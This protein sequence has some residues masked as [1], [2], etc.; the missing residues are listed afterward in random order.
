VSGSGVRFSD[1]LGERAVY[2]ARLVDPARPDGLVLRLSYPQHKW[3]SI[4]TSAGTIVGA[5]VVC[6]LL[7]TS[8]LWLMLQRQWIAP[9]RR[10]AGAATRNGRRRVGPTARDRPQPP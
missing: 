2:V 9:V 8:L 5:A 1:T 3:A 6:A 10:L 7:V 4:G